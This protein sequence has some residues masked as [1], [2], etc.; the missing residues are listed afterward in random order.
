MLKSSDK[1]LLNAFCFLQI[2]S[3]KEEA[4]CD[5]RVM[6]CYNAAELKLT[7]MYLCTSR[8]TRNNKK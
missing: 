1:L 8:R 3:T 6:W 2:R 5:A 7:Y 4:F